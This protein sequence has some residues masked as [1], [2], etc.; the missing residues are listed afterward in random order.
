VTMAEYIGEAL[1]IRPDMTI[2]PARVGEVT[3]Y[4]ANIG[5]ARALLNYNPATPLRE[6]IHKAV[7]WAAEWWSRQTASGS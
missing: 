7:A 3:R 5:K 1:G 4:I 6:G 2:K